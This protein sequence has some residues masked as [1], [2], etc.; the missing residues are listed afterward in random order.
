MTGPRRLL[1]LVALGTAL[2]APAA[3][4]ASTYG[5]YS[6]DGSIDGCNYSGGAL[7]GALGS[8]PTDVAQYDPRYVDALNKALA[9]RAAGCGAATTASA[10]EPKKKAA[11]T[12]TGEAPMPP[13]ID[14][15]VDLTGSTDLTA[16]HGLPTALWVLSGLVALIIAATATVAYRRERE[17]TFGGR[18]GRFSFFTDY[19]WGIRDTIG[20]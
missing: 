18:R 3:A 5:D 10:V 4:H 16:N 19:Y 17:P 7:Q 12:A 20:R 14:T 15:G 9:E 6:S 11:A 2:A 8:V 1:T 13:A